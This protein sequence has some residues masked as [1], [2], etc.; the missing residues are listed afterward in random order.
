[1]AVA[2][3]VVVT[4]ALIDAGSTALDAIPEGDPLGASKATAKCRIKSFMKIHMPTTDDSLR[5]PGPN[6]MEVTTDAA[7]VTGSGD[8]PTTLPPDA[9]MLNQAQEMVCCLFNLDECWIPMAQ[10]V[11]MAVSK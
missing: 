6:E 7:T 1:M 8:A 2:S 11:G 4:M 3:G 10:A 9:P 5:N